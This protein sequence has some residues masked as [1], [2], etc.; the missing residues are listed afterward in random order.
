MLAFSLVRADEGEGPWLILTGDSNGEY[1]ADLNQFRRISFGSESLILS[2]PDNDEEV[3]ELLYSAFNHIEF[4]EPGE[5]SAI[6]NIAAV[7]S[8]TLTYR[9][10]EQLLALSTSDPAAAIG[11]FT[12]GGKLIAKSSTNSLSVA[13]LQ[14]GTYVAIGLSGSS[15]VT[16][17]FIK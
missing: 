1:A 16:I 15:S 8:I 13:S 7:E 6:E 17:K 10:E 5:N 12:L 9:R 4:G 14:P 3:I 11:V 2:N